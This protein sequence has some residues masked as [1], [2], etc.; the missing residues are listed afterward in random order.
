[1]ASVCFTVHSCTNPQ[2]KR[3]DIS[4]K[5]KNKTGAFFFFYNLFPTAVFSKCY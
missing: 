4:A 2:F 5:K 3:D 1:M